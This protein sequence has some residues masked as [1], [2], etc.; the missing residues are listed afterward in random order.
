LPALSQNQSRLLVATAGLLLPLTFAPFHVYYLAPVLLAVLFWAWWRVSPAEAAK[1]GFIFGFAAFAAGT[2]WLYISIHIFGQAPLWLSVILMLSLV[3][4]MAIYLSICGWLCAVCSG[5]PDWLCAGLVFPAGWTVIEWLRGWLFSGF[6]WLSVGYGQI[7]GPLQAWAPVVGV[8]GVTLITAALGGAILMLVSGAARERWIALLLGTL[9]LS[10]TAGLQGREWTRATGQDLQVSLVQ[11]S[12][13][14]DRK[15]LREQRTPTMELYRKLTFELADQDLVIWPEAA[16]PAVAQMV[17]DYLDELQREA[18]ARDMQL[19]LGILTY[20]PIEGQYSN[21]LMALGPWNGIYRKRHLVPFGE[22]FPVPSFVRSWLRL[23]S[24]PY[25]DTS[26]G[27][28]D[29][30]P[31]RAGSVSIAPSICY[32][33]AFGAEQRDFLPESGLLVN[34]SNDAWFGDS[35]AP[36]QHLQIARMRTLETGR[37]MLRATNTGITAIIG[38]DGKVLDKLPQFEAGVLTSVVQ[39][40]TGTTPFIRF[41]NYPAVLISFIL[42]AIGAFVARRN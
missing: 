26:A 4:A 10:G 7:D 5:Q 18:E 29:Q 37:F 30:N 40:R 3:L 20:D 33:D 25:S 9:I 36:H 11:G 2:Y 17:L 19:L 32:E 41:G 35:I 38:P 6:P 28:A 12:I 15:W 1:R 22:F 14:Q 31:L 34:V 24:L 39:P 21:T 16:V 27:D 8:Y 42:L 13:P 23:M